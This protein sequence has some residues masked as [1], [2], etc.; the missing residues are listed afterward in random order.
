MLENNMKL[1]TT[2]KTYIK[3]LRRLGLALEKL[4]SHIDRTRRAVDGRTDPTS[5]RVK[6]RLKVYDE[7]LEKQRQLA[8]KVCKNYETEQWN[9]FAQNLKLIGA[10]SSMINDDARQT[11]FGEQEVESAKQHYC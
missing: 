5:L 9:D 1:S 4:E 7:I 8:E 2:Q 6:S 10:L 3:A 11:V